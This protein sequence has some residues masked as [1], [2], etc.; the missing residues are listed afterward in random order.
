[1]KAFHKTK[2][3][4]PG[5]TLN[6]TFALVMKA[7]GLPPCHQELVFHPGRRWRFDFAFCGDCSRCLPGAKVAIEIEGG[8]FIRG[9]SGHTSGLAMTKDAEKYNQAVLDGWVLLRFTN[10]MLEENSGYVID[11][12]RR[13]LALRH[14][15]AS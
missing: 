3:A 6:Q 8:V 9:K 13:A 15:V 10:K 12:I 1:M 4:V 11:T 14:S 5:L 7:N 2:F